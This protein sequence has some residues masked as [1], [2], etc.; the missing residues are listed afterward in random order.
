MCHAGFSQELLLAFLGTIQI[1]SRCSNILPKMLS[2]PLAVT[3]QGFPW[4]CAGLYQALLGTLPGT[5]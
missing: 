1:S 2:G 5:L 3:A 4:C